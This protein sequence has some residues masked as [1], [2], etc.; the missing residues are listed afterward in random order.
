[1][2]TTID[3]PAGLHQRVKAYAAQQGLSFAAAAAEALARGMAPVETAS[4]AQRDEATG[5]LVFDFGRGQ[6]VT[7]DDVADLIDENV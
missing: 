1:M 3:I 5:L 7:N 4:I 6:T 2:R